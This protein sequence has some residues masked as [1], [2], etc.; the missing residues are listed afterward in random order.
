MQIGANDNHDEP[1]HTDTQ[2]QTRTHTHSHTHTH[3]ANINKGVSSTDESKT[4][5]N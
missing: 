4:T 2:T 5:F 1:I 3:P